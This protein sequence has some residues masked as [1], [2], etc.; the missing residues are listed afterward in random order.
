MMIR[1]MESKAFG[2]EIYRS[3]NLDREY[4]YRAIGRLVAAKGKV[5]MLFDFTEAE[6]WKTKKGGDESE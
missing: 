6:V 4:N 3:W 5:M 2:D 1:N